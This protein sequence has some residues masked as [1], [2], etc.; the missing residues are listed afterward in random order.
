MEKI[1]TGIMVSKS[2]EEIFAFLSKRES[3]LNF[4]PRMV[5]LT[6]TSQGDFAQIG[7]T[8]EGVLNYFGIKIPVKYEIIENEPNQKLAMNGWMGPV[9]FKDGYVLSKQ[10]DGT[11]VKFWLELNLSGWTRIFASFTGLVGKVHA[12]E[13]LR[14]LKR[15]LGG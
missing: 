15:E 10:N 5:S 12:W 2:V 1:E 9:T 7:G 6:Q 11:E 14:N 13:T 4:I 8:S 3:H